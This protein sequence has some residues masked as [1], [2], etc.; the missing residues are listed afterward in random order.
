VKTKKDL[1][2]PSED[3]AS[4]PVSTDIPAGVVDEV[5]DAEIS[6]KQHRLKRFIKT[7]KGKIIALAVV[8]IL[9][10]T[11]ILT[12]PFTR[13]ASLSWIIKKDV[14]VNLMDS[15]TKKPITDAK[16]SL[17]NV[18]SQSDKDG[19]AVLKSVGIGQYNLV[20]EKKYYTSY[21]QP[22][23]IPLFSQ[24]SEVKAII[25]AT[26]RQVDVTI[27][28]TISGI[29]L[30][31]V[32]IAA[33]DTSSS[34]NDSGVGTIV[35]PADKVQLS[36]TLSKDGYNT[37]TVN[38]TIDPNSTTPNVF[39]MTKAGSLFY[40]SKA[41]G[42]INVM[43]S[44]IDGTSAN[45]AVA[46]T[47][48]E[49]DSNT[50]LLS[51]RDWQYSVLKAS[52]DS[53]VD[54]L[55]L[56]D[57]SKSELVTFDEGDATFGLAGWSGHDFFYTVYRNTAHYW[58]NNRQALKEYNAETRTLTTIDQTA[59]SGNYD[60]DAQY[61]NFGSIYIM[62]SQVVYTKSWFYGAQYQY[63]NP[64]KTVSIISV[65]PSNGTKT[66]VKEIAAPYSTYIDTRLYEPQEMYIRLQTGGGDPTYYSY[67]NK[68]VMP[69][70]EIADT[71][72]YGN[73]PTY[74][75]SP[76]GK[77]SFWYEPRDGKNAIFIGDQNSAN[78]REIAP[79]SDFI[80]YGWYGADD[81]YLLLSKNG[82]ELYIAP[83]NTSGALQPVKITDYHKAQNY[84][85]YGYGY[86][87]Q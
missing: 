86:G 78:S 41:T 48:Q 61:Q 63:Q 57:S 49:S 83:A 74:L 69:T 19:N 10:I 30:S 4:D 71:K 42:K 28:D 70:T 64:G 13:Y 38:I 18:T 11:L 26:G 52:R 40:L 43:K 23:T 68:S 16:V 60:F 21:T 50:V 5:I 25:V 62:D 27:K 9:V 59:G 53:A 14:H 45:V 39:T 82:S 31:G 29:V 44:N 79:A 12:I 72:F 20:V 22:Y 17:G 36:G 87:G 33:S 66:T 81:D 77:K 35:L 6:K 56:Y 2:I 67:E 51:S 85:G 54:K 47:G 76:S 75:I 24:P 55:Y 58:D 73:Y 3:V 1:N 80:P 37:A 8:L 65:D 46:G 84:Q 7:K 34:T 15:A 32:T